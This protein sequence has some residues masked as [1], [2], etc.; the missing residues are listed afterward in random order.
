MIAFEPRRVRAE[1]AVIPTPVKTKMTVYGSFALTDKIW[2]ASMT[3]RNTMRM[4]ST[5]VRAMIHLRV[6]ASQLIYGIE[7][8]HKIDHSWLQDSL[9]FTDFS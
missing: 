9:S 5:L 4:I 8:M 2:E 3:T 1:S 7:R 6:L